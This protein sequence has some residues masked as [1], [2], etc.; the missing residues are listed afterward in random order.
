MQVKKAGLKKQRLDKRRYSADSPFFK[1]QFIF[2][3]LGEAVGS[4]VTKTYRFR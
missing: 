2:D 4:K 1:E 3:D